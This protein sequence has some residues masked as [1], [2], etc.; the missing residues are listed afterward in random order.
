M[1]F[2]I[3]GAINTGRVGALA[4]NTGVFPALSCRIGHS[5]RYPVMVPP[6]YDVLVG[7]GGPGP[8]F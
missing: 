4:I 8:H 1:N 5:L 2:V 3:V 6:T 7:I